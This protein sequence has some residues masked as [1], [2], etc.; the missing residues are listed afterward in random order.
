LRDVAHGRAG[1]S[2]GR[3][4]ERTGGGAGRA[5][6]GGGR[7]LSPQEISVIHE[8]LQGYITDAGYRFARNAD[9]AD[10]LV[11]VRFTPNALDPKGGHVAVTGV[12]PNPLKRRGGQGVEGSPEGQEM[13]RKMRDLE[14]WIDAQSKSS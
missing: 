11:T 6:R 14:R 5:D 12:E 9:V 1:N 4:A 7:T 8:A 13:Q 3:R 10:F 2:P